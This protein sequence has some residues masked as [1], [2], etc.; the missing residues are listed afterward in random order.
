MIYSKFIKFPKPNITLE[1]LYDP[2]NQEIN[3]YELD[4]SEIPLAISSGIIIDIYVKPF[5]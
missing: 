4:M 5:Y 2:D 1:F 3:M